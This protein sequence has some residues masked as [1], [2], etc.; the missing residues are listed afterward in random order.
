M[1]PPRVA[2]DAMGKTSSDRIG[3]APDGEGGVLVAWTSAANAGN[4]YDV[5]AQR[6]DGSGAAQWNPGGVEVCTTSGHQ[7]VQ[8]VAEP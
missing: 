6:F 1:P 4:G 7:L 2:V 5:L 3:L 8:P